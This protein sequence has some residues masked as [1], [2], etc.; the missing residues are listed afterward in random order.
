MAEVLT[1]NRNHFQLRPC[2][3]F[4]GVP[5]KPPPPPLKA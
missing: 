5:K 1:G 4:G 3:P 2:G